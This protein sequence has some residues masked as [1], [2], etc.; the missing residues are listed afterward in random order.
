MLQRDLL[1]QVTRFSCWCWQARD[2]RKSRPPLRWSCHAEPTQT[3]SMY[4]QQY[5]AVASATLFNFAH[6]VFY[7]RP[8]VYYSRCLLFLFLYYHVA[9][10]LLFIIFKC[11]ILVSTLQSAWI[12]LD[13][14]WWWLLLLF[15]V[16]YKH[17]KKRILSFQKG[18]S[19]VWFTS[20]RVSFGLSF[21]FLLEFW[22]LWDN[23]ENT[24]VLSRLSHDHPRSLFK[25]TYIEIYIPL[26]E[27]AREKGSWVAGR[28]TDLWIHTT[29]KKKK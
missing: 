4:G 18:P 28:R 20:L 23:R 5:M 25:Y 2:K 14:L 22:W 7:L 21:Y 1:H 10:T 15:W 11:T 9:T 27:E 3:F 16:L 8:V 17:N 19:L 26:P 6:G 12:D 24:A 13:L 29:L